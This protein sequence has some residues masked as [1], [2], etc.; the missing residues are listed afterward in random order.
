MGGISY[1]TAVAIAK[2]WD[3]IKDK[4]HE[5]GSY[6]FQ[7]GIVLVEG[8][9]VAASISTGGSLFGMIANG[10]Q[11]PGGLSGLAGQV[12]SGG[13]GSIMQNPMGTL[14]SNVSGGITG[15]TDALSGGLTST[16]DT[17]I[18][19]SGVLTTALDTALGDLST[20]LGGFLDHTDLLSG[21]KELANGLEDNLDF[22]N[23]INIGELANILGDIDTTDLIKNTASGLFADTDLTNIANDL[24][25]NL[26]S[27]NQIGDTITDSIEATN[28][29][30]NVISNIE[31]Q[32]SI[33]SNIISNDNNQFNNITNNVNA[34]FD[35]ASWTD[36]FRTNDGIANVLIERVANT[37]TLK[38]IKD[39]ITSKS[40]YW[41]SSQSI[42][43]GVPYPP[44]ESNLE[45]LTAEQEARFEQLRFWDDE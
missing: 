34:V 29:V 21:V 41:E 8:K 31:S 24:T 42:P 26:T 45:P 28:L 33:L 2:K 16:I 3:D 1:G 23:L 36:S 22:K 32:N 19:D 6:L 7:S 25:K 37:D 30:N 44:P 12:L 20:Q 15:I 9:K 17:V 40:N 38:T 43:E 14:I 18:G 13:L 10:I 4:I 39:E 11:L 27:L 5:G 35:I